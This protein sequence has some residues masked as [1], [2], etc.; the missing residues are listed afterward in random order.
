ML[1]GT[2]HI[3]T[4]SYEVREGG[5]EGELVER[6]D[7]YYP[8]KFLFGTGRL[9]P[10]FEARLKGLSEGASFSFSLS[11]EEAYGRVESGNIAHIPLEVFAASPAY[12][13]VQLTP[14]LFVSLTD[15][16]GDRHHGKIVALTDTSAKVD[17]NHAL[18]GKTLFFSGIVLA[19]RPATVDELIRKH[20][21][22]ADGVHRS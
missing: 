3:I 19:I 16:L 11:P 9:L 6:M 8:F 4:L 20:Y 13:G 18:A 22:E 2:E 7:N 21:I 14:D 10:A 5:P 17:F 15:D 1:V 12:R